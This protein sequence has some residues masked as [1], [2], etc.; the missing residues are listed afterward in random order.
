MLI[1][2]ALTAGGRR[3]AEM[4]TP[5]REAVYSPSTASATP[6]PLGIATSIPTH[7]E[8]ISHLM[9]RFNKFIHEQSR[10]SGVRL[11]RWCSQTASL[12]PPSLGLTIVSVKFL[13]YINNMVKFDYKLL[14]LNNI[15]KAFYL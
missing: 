5:T 13:R 11:D 12:I 8:R 3:D 6:A 15:K 14:S 1:L 4:A 7:N 2:T 10:L 9:Q